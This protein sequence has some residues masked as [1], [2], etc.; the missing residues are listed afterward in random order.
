MERLTALLATVEGVQIIGSARTV[1]AAIRG[2]QHL[3]PD[4]V[5]L[6]FQM[7]DGTGRDVLKAIKHSLV[8]SLVMMLTNISYP[9]FRMECMQW[10]ADYFFD[11]SQEFEQVSEV[12][13]NL[14][15]VMAT[16][17]RMIKE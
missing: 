1:S 5:I 9:Q 7:P 15:A 4:L 16:K 8:P 3:S 10:G 13:R 2:I 14:L 11:K 17:S 12:C 6:D